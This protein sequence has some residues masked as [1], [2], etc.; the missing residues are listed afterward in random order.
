MRVIVFGSTGMLGRYC[1]QLLG[2]KNEVIAVNREMIDASKCSGSDLETLLNQFF[3]NKMTFDGSKYEINDI[4]SCLKA[5]ADECEAINILALMN[6]L[7]ETVVI[8][9]IGAI[10]QRSDDSRHFISVNTLFPHLLSN[11]CRRLGIKMIHITTDCV[12]SGNKGNYQETDPHDE[13]GIYGV[14]KSLGEPKDCCVIRTSIIGEELYNKRSLLEWV[15]EQNGKQ[16]FGY[17]NHFWNGVT[18]LQLSKIIGEIIEKDMFWDGV[19]HIHSPD[20]VSKHDLIKTII[21]VYDLKV[22]LR[23]YPTDDVN[24]T[25]GSINATLFDIPDIETQILQQKSFHND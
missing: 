13:T 18:C 6:S 16:I 3:G 4:P 5:F 7:K 21:D 14:T 10:P 22:D 2:E 25:L 17:V 19:K 9:C 20:S 1:C 23:C 8:N 15:R 11:A 24:K 12:F